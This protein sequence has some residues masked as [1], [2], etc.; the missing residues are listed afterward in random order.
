MNVRVIMLTA[1]GDPR[2]LR[3]RIRAVMRRTAGE[4]GMDPLQ[5][6]AGER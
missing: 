5:I 3:A 2:E 6:E 4:I 1:S